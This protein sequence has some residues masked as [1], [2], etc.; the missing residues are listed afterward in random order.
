MRRLVLLALA[1]GCSPKGL[2]P[3]S[4]DRDLV[5]PPPRVADSDIVRDYLERKERWAV[6]TG[7]DPRARMV[8]LDRPRRATVAELTRLPKPADLT[9]GVRHAPIETTLFQVEVEIVALKFEKGDQDVHMVI[10][11]PKRDPKRTMVVEFAD[12][13]VVSRSSPFRDRIVAARRALYETY[14]PT[15]RF[16]GGGKRRARIRGVGFFDHL[17]GQRGMSPNGLELHPVLHFELID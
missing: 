17:H 6:K 2:A 8:S 10:R 11:D 9:D 1:A 7:A 3:A 13:T 15:G 14:R 12:P 5:L 4:L 16:V